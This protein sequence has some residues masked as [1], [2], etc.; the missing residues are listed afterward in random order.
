MRNKNTTTKAQR[1]VNRIPTAE[2]SSK[3]QKTGK[4]FA[5]AP[6]LGDG[7]SYDK[8]EITTIK[9]PSQ[10]EKGATVSI[11]RSAR[12]VNARGETKR[13]LNSW[14]QIERLLRKNNLPIYCPSPSE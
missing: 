6:L 4:P 13:T 9:F 2:M 5:E 3:N 14:S 8:L 11:L 10:T 7:N 1:R 12:L